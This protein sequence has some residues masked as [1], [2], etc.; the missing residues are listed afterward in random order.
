MLAAMCAH[1]SGFLHG[2]RGDVPA[3]LGALDRAADEYA[4]LGV[5]AGFAAVL[6]VDRAQV[7]L[8]AGLEREAVRAAARAV[9][10]LEPTGNSAELA[11]AQLLH[12]RSLLASDDPGAEVADA[13]ARAFTRRAGRR[14]RC[15]PSTSA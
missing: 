9:E 3:A 4:D 11:E 2:R 5:E 13:A 7:L 6:Q 15:S 14:G 12:A 1:N 8:D 10:L